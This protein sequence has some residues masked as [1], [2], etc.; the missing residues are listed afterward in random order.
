MTD[1]LH[2]PAVEEQPPWG[3]TW[4]RLYLVVAAN[5]LFWIVLLVVLTRAFS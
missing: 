2:V 3:G 1:G 5:L 4:R